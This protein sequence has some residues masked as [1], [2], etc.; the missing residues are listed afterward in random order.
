MKIICVDDENL[1]LEL[2]VRLCEELPQ[3]NEVVSFSSS[4]EALE[5]M[6]NN[7]ADLALLDI[8]MPKM[9]GIDALTEVMKYDPDANVIMCSDQKYES[10]IMMALKKGA[11]DFVIKPFTSYDILLAVKK[12]FE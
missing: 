12:L 1:V 5:Y 3:I 9:N 4:P 7:S 6:K 8:E 10:M 2:V 11:K